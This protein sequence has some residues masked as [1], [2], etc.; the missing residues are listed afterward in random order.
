MAIC[1]NLFF[2]I[3]GIKKITI[4]KSRTQ[5]LVECVNFRSV[6]IAKQ[7]SKDEQDQENPNDFKDPSVE[8]KERLLAVDKDEEEEGSVKEEDTDLNPVSGVKISSRKLICV[9]ETSNVFTNN[10]WMRFL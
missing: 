9:E 10:Y 8:E 6:G 1:L 4:K 2:C 5:G 7:K 3:K